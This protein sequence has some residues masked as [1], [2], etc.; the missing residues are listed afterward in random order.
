MNAPHPDLEGEAF[1]PP[2]RWVGLLATIGPLV[3]FGLI[4]LAAFQLAGYSTA[5]FVLSIAIG[6]FVGGGK[7]VI[8]AGAIET[9]PVGVWPLAA[10]VVYG[11]LATA[12][13]IVSNMYH[14]YRVPALGRRLAAAREAG[15][16]VLRTHKW[17]RR[18]AEVGLAVF[19]AVPFQGTGA[20]LG[21]VLGRLLG[22]SRLAILVSITIGSTSGAALI[23]VLGVV[24]RDEIT[25]L[26]DNSF[27]GIASIVISLLTTFLLGKWFLGRSPVPR[28]EVVR[29]APAPH[30]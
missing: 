10:L 3:G 14:V 11:D 13:V 18:A 1:R 2:P 29:D 5:I 30:N 6:G 17:M 25:K 21:V 9:A 24:A 8:L 12:L 22:L 20:V 19:V 23:A 27:L 15:F 26:A 28:T 7:L 4:L 16:R